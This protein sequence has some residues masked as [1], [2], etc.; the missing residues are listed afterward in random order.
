MRKVSVNE[1]D[2][3]GNEKKYLNECI[4]SGWISSEGPFLKRFEEEMAK[5]TGRKYGIAVSNGSTALDTVMIALKIGKNDEVIMPTFTIISC[6]A[7]VVR[8]GAKPVLVDVNPY[9][10]NMDVDQIEKK[11]TP[12]TKAIMVVH[13]Y[14]LPVDMDPVMRLAKKYALFV[15]EDAAEAH[16]QMYRGKACGSFGDISTFSFYPNK[17]ITC[18]EGGMVLTDDEKLAYRCRQARNLFFDEERRYI[19]QEIGYNFRMSNLQAAVGLAQ[20]ERIRQTI[21]KKRWIGQLY[22]ELLD[23]VEEIQL[24]QDK[25]SYAQNIYWVYGVI[26]SKDKGYSVDHIMQELAKNEIGTRHFFWC[27]HEQPVFQRINLFCGEVYPQAE[28]LARRGFYLPSGVTLQ[29]ED[30]QYVAKVLKIILLRMK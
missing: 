2:L 5:L 13:I 23:E 24:P 6:A 8:V 7:A 14:G 21:E 12:K 22:N 17:H 4:D 28:R 18:G 20:L 29:E 3:S 19:H 15:I 27:M 10:W 16:G 25:T 9:T 1:P 30:I 11:I 26:I